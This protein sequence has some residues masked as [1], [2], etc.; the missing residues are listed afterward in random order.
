MLL[1]RGT[2]FNSCDAIQ[3]MTCLRMIMLSTLNLC[4]TCCRSNRLKL[5][6]L[7]FTGMLINL[8][9]SLPIS[10]SLVGTA[11]VPGEF[12]CRLS[13]STGQK[14][15]EIITKDNRSLTTKH[16]RLS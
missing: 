12:Y 10:Q 15:C 4:E 2:P 13:K 8:F 11:S 5:N 1:Y 3:S 6:Q 9:I 16:L 7:S 14:Q